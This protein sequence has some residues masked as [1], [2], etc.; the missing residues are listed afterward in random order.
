L[1]AEVGDRKLKQEHSG[2]IETVAMSLDEWRQQQARR[3]A[4]AAA[5]IDDFADDGE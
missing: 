1:A 3:K 4:Q 5:T 2:T